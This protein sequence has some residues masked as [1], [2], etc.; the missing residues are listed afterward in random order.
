MPHHGHGSGKKRDR[1][2]SRSR[3]KEKRERKP[4]ASRFDDPNPEK[5]PEFVPPPGTQAPIPVPNPHRSA[6]SS[7]S[8]ASGGFIKPAHLDPTALL[9]DENK[10]KVKIY[11]PKDGSVNY[12]GLIIGPKGMYQKKLEEQTNC[13]ILIRGKGSVQRESMIPG[14]TLQP[15]PDD[16]EEQHVLIVGDTEKD[17]EKAQAAINSV[18]NADE[19]TRNAIRNEQLRSAQ[20]INDKLYGT[21]DESLLTPYGPPSPSAYI[22]PVPNDCVGLI[23]GKGGETI[24]QLQQESGAKIQVAKKEVAE[25]GQRNVFVEGTPERYEHAKRLIEAIVAEHQGNFTFDQNTSTVYYPVPN[26]MVGLLIGKNGDNL[27]NMMLR[28]RAMIHVPKVPEPGQN[29]RMVQIRGTKS[30]IENVRREVAAFISNLNKAATTS[31]LRE[32]QQAVAA[33]SMYLPESYAGVNKS[34]EGR[35][36]EKAAAEVQRQQQIQNELAS[37]AGLYQQCF[38]NYDPLYAEYFQKQY[39]MSTENTA[40]KSAAA[41]VQEAYANYNT[42]YNG[43]LESGYMAPPPKDEGK[44]ETGKKKPGRY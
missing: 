28:T 20:E 41:A 29:Q 19:E 3:S 17:I 8:H 32:K 6:W 39:Q 21:V 10:L 14:V 16:N 43:Y 26:S 27:K 1:S 18:L 7:Q 34:E 5:L 2:R 4:R 37:Y 44:K 12:I 22:I 42:Y 24:R 25:T 13:R 9:N 33:I 38:A 11:L 15:S 40:Q 30:Q 36:E 31:Q 23:I 35:E